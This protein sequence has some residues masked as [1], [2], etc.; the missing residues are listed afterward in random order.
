MNRLLKSVL[1]KFELFRDL[2]EGRSVR[3]KRE[4]GVFLLFLDYEVRSVP[5]YGHGKP[6]H[7][8]LF[9][10][11]NRNR[12]DY[13]ETLR[14]FLKFKD[15]LQQIPVHQPEDLGMPY[16]HN[17]FFEG[18][19]AVSLYSIASLRNP[20]TYIE[21]GSGNSTKFM[22]KAIQDN[23]LRTRIISIDPRPRADIDQLCDEMRRGPL[24]QT[25][26]TVFANLV[27]GDILFVD[28]SHRTFMNS[29]VSVVFLDVLPKLPPGVLIYIDDVYLP[30]DY[31]PEWISR[32]YSEQYLLAALLLAEGERFE[33][34][35]PCT[36]IE[37][38]PELQRIL[39][40]LWKP[41]AGAAVPGHG[42]WLVTR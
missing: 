32:Y 26:L 21:V 27:A 33:V 36:F 25:D 24:E 14:Q 10:I 41:I 17:R 5:R 4:H 28:G 16:W 11:F 34:F 37:Q 35:L 20:Q 29:D 9:E 22:R 30:F 6:A 13:A 39:D 12:S 7:A 2:R 15:K 19:D 18:L 3:I 31:P 38:D 42:F 40:P 1:L 8:E 23:G